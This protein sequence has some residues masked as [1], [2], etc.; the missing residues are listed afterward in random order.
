MQL[1]MQK[2][3]RL[4]LL[5]NKYYIFFVVSTCKFLF[6]IY[7]TV[8]GPI[9]VLLGETFHINLKMQSFVFPSIFFGQAIIIFFI[10]FIS[11]KI[12]KKIV[13]LLSL[14]I[15][16]L[17]SI[18]FLFVTS[19][20]EILLLFLI[21]GITGS[22]M[23]LLSD[24]TV[25][26]TFKNNKSFYMNLTHV[27]FGLGALTSPII[28]NIL[29]SKT[30]NFRLIFV[31]LFLCSI[32][33]FFLVIPIRYPKSIIEKVNLSNIKSIISNKTFIY[34]S[35]IFMLAAGSSNTISV[36][37]PTI[38]EKNLYISKSLSNYSLV[39]FWS[40]MVLGRIIT[41]YLSKKNKETFLLRNYS[42]AIFVVL[43]ISGFFSKFSFLL[44]S[45]MLFG[46]LM[47]GVLPLIQ[48]YSAIFHKE[49]TGIKIGLL[50]SSAAIGSIIIP[51]FVG[52]LGDYYLIN[53]IIP[54]TSIFFL[55]MAIYFSLRKK[56]INF[57]N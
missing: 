17:A 54:F 50:T 29:Y 56:I 57:G 2:I 36:W 52:F 38:F 27:F 14:L 35:I 53:K 6:G 7:S 40:S 48:S 46:L 45:Y 25:A 42:L 16:G 24:V 28:F 10:G 15:F 13:Q 23:N 37:I 49:F 22:G 47:G 21:T 9:L 44:I 43:V 33:I 4:K 26:D 19:Y 18:L 32:I 41:A 12:G 39:F 55:I 20:P 51:M 5:D 3:S 8:V 31:V 1:L 34:L 30:N 11:D